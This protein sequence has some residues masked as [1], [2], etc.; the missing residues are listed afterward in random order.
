VSQFIARDKSQA[1]SKKNYYSNT[2]I[3]QINEA[4]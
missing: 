1:K 2:T 3:N 4:F